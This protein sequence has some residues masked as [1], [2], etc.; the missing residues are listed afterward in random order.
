MRLRVAIAAAAL[1]AVAAV[2]LFLALDG[3]PWATAA[4]Y[5]EQARGTLVTVTARHGPFEVGPYSVS[6][7]QPGT[8]RIQTPDIDGFVVQMHA[9]LVDEHGRPIPVRRMML[10]HV[11][12]A[13]RGRFDGDRQDPACPHVSE[14]FYGTG[15]ENHT[16]RLPPGYG[17]RIRK[18]DRWDTSWM[19]MNHRDRTERAYIEYE[20][21]IDTSRDLEHVTPYWLRATGCRN[22]NDPIFNVPGGG[23]P[24]STHPVSSTFRMPEAGRLIAGGAHAHGGSKDLTISQPAC[25]DRQLM[26]SRPLYGRSDHPYYNVLPVLHEPGPIDMSWVQTRTGIPVGK[27]EPLRVTSYYDGELPHTRAMGIMH[28]YVAHGRGGETSCAP[29]PADLENRGKDV[30]GRGRPP[31]F[32]VPLAGIDERGQARAIVAPPGPR[33]R[34]DGDATVTVRNHAFRERNLS[35]PAGAR[36]SWRFEDEELH[37]VTVAD[38]PLGF[39][40]QNAVEG[41]T[42]SQRLTRPGRYGLFC[43]LHPV[44]MT[45]SITVRPSG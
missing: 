41:D 7:T 36:V 17:Y 31:R 21:T 10:H 20:A 22:R 19:L 44:T 5:Q 39:A 9:R 27:G 45:Q 28:L 6:Y 13:N 35:V 34:T 38:G 1:V 23:P 32:R 24:G 26:V 30:P 25:R 18:G 8:D 37:N 12:I 15:E 14:S 42:F 43:S 3:G 2:G 4:Y 11:V 40:S 29:L 33:V 16:L